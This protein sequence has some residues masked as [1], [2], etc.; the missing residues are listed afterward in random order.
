MT[1]QIRGKPKNIL[2]GNM[3][4]KLAYI[5]NIPYFQ[6]FLALSGLLRLSPNS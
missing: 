5:A 4:S 6:C 1:V 3:L 2:I